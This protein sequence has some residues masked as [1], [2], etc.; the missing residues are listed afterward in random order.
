MTRVTCTRD[1]AVVTMELESAAV[2]IDLARIMMAKG[3]G[4][5]VTPAPKAGP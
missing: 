4:V 2:A 3:Y 5:E 1:G